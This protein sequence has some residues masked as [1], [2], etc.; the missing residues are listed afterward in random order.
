MMNDP[1]GMAPEGGGG[2]EGE[3][4]GGGGGQSN[5]PPTNPYA[6]APSVSMSYEDQASTATWASPIPSPPNI[7]ANKTIKSSVPAKS[8]SD[9]AFW[10]LQS[11]NLGVDLVDAKKPDPAATT[12]SSAAGKTYQSD[13]DNAHLKSMNNAGL[14]DRISSYQKTWDISYR[15]QVDKAIGE[16]RDP[17]TVMQPQAAWVTSKDALLALGGVNPLIVGNQIRIAPR[18]KAYVGGAAKLSTTVY[19]VQG[20]T[21]PNESQN[22]VNINNTGKVKIG[23]VK[24]LNVSVGD[25]AHAEYFAKLRMKQYT[26]VG[27]CPAVYSFEIPAWAA[28]FMIGNAIPQK[29]YRSNPL[30]QNG[31]A[32]KV[33]DPTTPGASLELPAPWSNWLQEVHIPKSGRVTAYFGN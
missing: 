6:G 5:P 28:N 9:K 29:G 25:A 20:G 27:D 32:P 4:G 31:L 24:N 33:N 21:S 14:L 30:N 7:A 12:L 17:S 15:R 11:K 1:S 8:A 19:R 18:Q 23:T 13:L 3:S 10:A 26:G 2:D 16:G 22:H